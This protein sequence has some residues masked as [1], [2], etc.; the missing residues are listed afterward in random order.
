MRA[1]TL[2]PAAR[3]DLFTLVLP[4][5]GHVVGLEDFSKAP[6]E[7]ELMYGIFGPGARRTVDSSEMTA[8][9]AVFDNW[10]R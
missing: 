1:R 6:L 4:A 5:L 3:L 7:D 9:D 2:N 10:S 8:V